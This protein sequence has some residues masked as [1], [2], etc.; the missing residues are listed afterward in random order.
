MS[1]GPYL[2]VELIGGKFGGQYVAVYPAGDGELPG[3][4]FVGEHPYVRFN[5]TKVYFP[6]DEGEERDAK[7]KPPPI[8]LPLVRR[9]W[10][11]P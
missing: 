3:K 5:K 11:I 9:P 1:S 8:N 6:D 4:I 2:M 7:P 10:P